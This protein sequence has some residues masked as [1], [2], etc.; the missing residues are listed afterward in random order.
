M[1]QGTVKISFSMLSQQTNISVVISNKTNKEIRKEGEFSLGWKVDDLENTKAEIE[2]VIKTFLEK[3]AELT[4][5]YMK[6]KDKSEEDKSS[7]TLEMMEEEKKQTAIKIM[8]KVAECVIC[9][10]SCI[11]KKKKDETP[12]KKKRNMEDKTYAQESKHFKL[13]KIIISPSFHEET[14]T[15]EELKVW[16]TT[17]KESDRLKKEH[18]VDFG[19]K[20]PKQAKEVLES[21]WKNTDEAIK[22]QRQ[23]HAEKKS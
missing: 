12:I 19:N 9:A 23:A 22:K 17:S 14:G 1:E 15:A 13:R 7:K 6:N 18:M 3:N 20:I 2:E 4:N 8:N 11:N 16:A 21:I 5:E 10:D